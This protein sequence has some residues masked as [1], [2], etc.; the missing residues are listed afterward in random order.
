METT[1]KDGN[2]KNNSLPLLQNGCSPIT[3]TTKTWLTANTQ[4]NEMMKKI[5]KCP[6]AEADCCM[7]TF[8]NVLENLRSDIEMICGKNFSD[9]VS[10]NTIQL[11]MTLL[12]RDAFHRCRNE[13]L[14]QS[15]RSDIQA[16]RTAQKKM[17]I[18]RV[19][20]KY[21]QFVQNTTRTYY[22]AEM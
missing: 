12:E 15:I 11:N 14:L 5:P 21:E 13:D 3:E 7:H 22:S 4:V 10:A 6:A 9:L 8:Y 17:Y 19:L 16:M 2:Q 18:W 20:E 1:R